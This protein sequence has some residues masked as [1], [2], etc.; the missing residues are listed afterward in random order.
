MGTGVGEKDVGL[1]AELIEDFGESE[2]GADGVSV[3]AGVRG[4]EKAGLAAEEGQ[5]FSD[6]A[7]VRGGFGWLSCLLE[8]VELGVWSHDLV[9][10]GEA[11]S[12]T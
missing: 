9:V 4:E 10:T 2:D 8:F 11:E 3:G 1:A 6:A 5:E 12:A 7:L